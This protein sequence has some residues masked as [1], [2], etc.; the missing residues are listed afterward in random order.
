MG[1]PTYTFVEVWILAQTRFGNGPALRFGRFWLDLGEQRLWRGE[2]QI[3]LR[4]K[5]LAVLRYLSERSGR[6]VGRDELLRAVWPKTHVSD[7][8]LKVCVREVRQALDDDA[9]SSR[10]IETVPREGYRWI[11]PITRTTTKRPAGAECGARNAMIGREEELRRLF[12]RLDEATRGDRRVVFVTGEAGIG[13]TA[14]VDELLGRLGGFG[15]PRI[16]RGQC[17]E[18]YGPGEAYLAFLDALT[19]LCRGPDAE[20][21]VTIL[22]RHAPTWLMQMP[23]L[24]D[25]KRLETLR[26]RTQGG[27]RDRM[28]REMA[29]ALEALTVERPLVLVLEDLQWADYSTLDLLASL[30]RRSAA[31]RILLIGTYRPLDAEAANHSVAAVKRE[32]QVHGACDEL[33]LAPLSESEIARYLAHR[34]E[35]HQ[36]PRELGATLHRGSGGNPLLIANVV[37]DLTARNVITEIEG[38]WELRAGMDEIRVTLPDGLRES[39]ERQV[40]RLG[41][42]E[43]RLLGVASVSGE[44]FLVLPVAE[45]MLE[46]PSEVEAIAEGLVRRRLFIRVEGSYAYPDGTVTSRYAF[47]H[48]VYQ[49]VLYERL[50][51]GLRA[52]LHKVIAEV[53]ERMHGER[54][55]DV[56]AELA[57]HFA[58]AGDQRRM[59]YLELAGDVALRRFANHEAIGYLREALE[60][61]ERAPD[62]TDRRTKE[63]ELLLKLGTPLVAERGFAAPEVIAAYSRAHELSRE[64]GDPSQTFAA[65]LGLYSA[66]LTGTDL[67]QAETIARSLDSLARQTDRNDPRA[68]LRAEAHYAFGYA[69]F[70]RGD[71]ATAT[72]ELEKGIES[73]DPRS[74]ITH[75]P[76]YGVDPSV[77]CSSQLGWAWWMQG[78]ADHAL[79]RATSAVECARRLGSPFDL[80]MALLFLATTHLLRREYELAEHVADEGIAASNEYGLPYWRTGATLCRG[81]AIAASG[82]AEEGIAL[83][84]RGLAEWDAA[85]MAT[86]STMW[87]GQLAEAL[88]ASGDGRAAR[89]SLNEAF[90]RVAK[91]GEHWWKAELHRQRGELVAT[92]RPAAAETFFRDALEIAR[93]QGAHALEL[94]AAT[95]LALLWRQERPAQARTELARAYRGVREG[96]ATTDLRE[97]SALL[98][99]LS[100]AA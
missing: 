45:A 53:Q 59:R 72:A 5:P 37:N 50:G 95:S 55:A 71:L 75:S 35:P 43:R 78:R 64:V 44:E 42:A 30:A 3:K 92:R 89:Q 68:N 6:V 99:E 26:L 52:Q 87:L 61:L 86:G 67:A 82:R 93:R 96:L 25:E 56:A 46:S 14:L 29:E 28:L 41:E 19:E 91:Y 90:S 54:V 70:Y 77:S 32:L 47:E 12:G 57:T 18:H 74:R 73:Y 39:V 63:L 69:I 24:V 83:L 38:T 48:G 66:D 94:R 31:A 17:I 22:D 58:R 1:H 40:D 62:T 98:A 20:A 15:G 80:G 85:G 81:S 34:F 27:T 23:A 11:A 2:R 88:R 60:L 8:V 10:F 13:K 79:E 9:G 4:P 21:S 65:L 36:F 7:T 76:M 49:K 33:R 16:A 51:S 84:R 97:A 100:A